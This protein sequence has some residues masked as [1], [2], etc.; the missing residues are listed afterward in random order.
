MHLVL[1]SAVLKS[2]DTVCAQISTAC[3]GGV[4]L[5]PLWSSVILAAGL[6]SL[7]LC[8]SF[9]PSFLAS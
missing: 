5:I 2:L 4:N 3:Y 7:F 9:L 6:S 1:V 8:P